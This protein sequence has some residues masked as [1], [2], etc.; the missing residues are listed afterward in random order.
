MDI[1]LIAIDMDGTLLNNKNEITNNTQKV[2]K[3][4]K[5]KGVKIVLTT[6][7]V[8][9]SAL[10]FS[11][12]LGLESYVIACNGGIIVDNQTNVLFKKP[13]P[14]DKMMKIME[15][16]K[17]FSVYFHF[18]NEDTFFT[19]Q[20]VKEV[21][22]YYSSDHG[23]FTGQSIGFEL[24]EKNSE[25]LDRM[26]LDIYKFL[27]IDQ[28]QEKLIKL[29]GKLSK[30]EDISLS[31]SWENNVEIMNKGVSKGTAISL[32]CDKLGIN[33]E[34][35]MAIGDNENDLSMVEFA[36]IGVAMGNGNSILKESADFIA[37]T[38]E[39]DGVAYAIQKF[40]L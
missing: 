1:K 28:E 12:H 7:R 18:Y 5:E 37:P 22:E 25:I 8:L 16:G 33:S 39:E 10:Y 2:L 9:K 40:V 21:D 13:I 3:A 35:V 17:E 24:Y 38:N 4:A 36:G 23:K 27:F 30:I 32:L 14:K 15:I 26:D 31:S 34:N 29:R 6:G 19:N 20:Y 11:N